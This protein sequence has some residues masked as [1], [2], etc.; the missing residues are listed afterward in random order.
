MSKKILRK[1]LLLSIGGLVILVLIIIFTLWLYN[2]R[3]TGIKEHI[4]TSFNLP[5]GRIGS[6]MFYSKDL[7][8]RYHTNKKM[9]TESVFTDSVN[10]YL[11]DEQTR[12]VFSQVIHNSNT[13]LIEL[14]KL[15]LKT[16]PQ[17]LQAPDIE[18]Q[19]ITDSDFYKYIFP[20]HT[21]ELELKIHY[22]SQTELHPVAYAETE[23]IKNLLQA[24]KTPEQI[25]NE[26]NK[27]S[28]SMAF[29]SRT[30][31]TNEQD[32]LSEYQLALH[33]LPI[34]EIVIVPTR[35]GLSVL[36]LQDKIATD[37]KI[38][39]DLEIFVFNLNGFMAWLKTQQATIPITLFLKYS[40]NR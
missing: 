23:K 8:F 18:L 1:I 12:L 6:S 24:N 4:L 22:H 32:L 13:K 34:G 30:G 15:H 14:E 35:F 9:K 25:Y 33:N 19:S 11:S 10:Q 21:M 26:L 20:R 17:S 37:S 2:G 7:M 16:P 29:T 3:L 40:D 5:I 36:K 27:T 31:Y 39:M 38:L 28:L